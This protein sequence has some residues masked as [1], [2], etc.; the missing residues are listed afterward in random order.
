MKQYDKIPSSPKSVAQL[1]FPKHE[2]QSFTR[3]LRYLKDW[4]SA[5]RTE[6]KKF[7]E[8]KGNRDQEN[9]FFTDQK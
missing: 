9:Q 6:S 7:T 4:M 1:Y 8:R 2:A 5:V 3:Q